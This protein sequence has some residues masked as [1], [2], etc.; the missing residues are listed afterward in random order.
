MT[1]IAYKDGVIAYDS[2]VTQGT[3]IYSDSANKRLTVGDLDIFYSGRVSDREEWADCYNDRSREPK[4]GASGAAFIVDGGNV[5]QAGISSED[6]FWVTPVESPAAIG[7][8][9][10]HALTAMD[11]GGSAKDAVKMAM[12]RDAATGGRV[13]TFKVVE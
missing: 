13:R 3:L 11:M 6:G 9:D 12:R 4:K 1:T 2:R 10:L 7:S 5:W 8:G